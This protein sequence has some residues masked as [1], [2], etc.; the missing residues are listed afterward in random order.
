MLCF[1]TRVSNFEGDIDLV[2]GP[3]AATF[4]V[5]GTCYGACADAPVRVCIELPQHRPVALYLRALAMMRG[6]EADWSV[7]RVEVP[8][9]SYFDFTRWQLHLP[10]VGA[11]RLQDVCGYLPVHVVMM[12]AD[13]EFVRIIVQ[14]RQHCSRLRH[15]DVN[16]AGT[17]DLSGTPRQVHIEL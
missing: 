16:A 11:V 10:L 17:V 13:Q 4:A 14:R 2:P 7:P 9:L 12:I 5:S 6:L 15:D 1:H 8:T 3:T